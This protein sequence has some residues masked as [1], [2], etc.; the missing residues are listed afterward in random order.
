MRKMRNTCTK[1]KESSKSLNDNRL[2][3]NGDCITN[4]VSTT[5]TNLWHRCGSAVAYVTQ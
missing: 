3:Q 4:V 2:E 1:Q 5:E